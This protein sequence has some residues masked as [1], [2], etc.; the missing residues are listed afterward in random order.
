MG[1]RYFVPLSAEN[2]AASGLIAGDEVDV[3][4]CLDTEP[5]EVTVPD[6]LAEVLAEDEGARR[7]FAGLSYTH[8][9]EWVRWIQ[10]AKRSETRNERIRKTIEALREG[11]RQR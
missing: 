10:E 3:D 2:R 7:F 11:K 6:D 9:K 5:R 4:I 8:R 1:G